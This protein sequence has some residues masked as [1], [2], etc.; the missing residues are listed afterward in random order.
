[1]AADFNG[2]GKLDLAMANQN[3]GTVSILLGNGN[4]TFQPPANVGGFITPTWIAVGDFNGDGKLDLAVTDGGSASVA[5]LLGNGDG[6]FAIG[7]AL[8]TNQFPVYVVTG[9]FNGDGKLDLAATDVPGSVPKRGVRVFLGNGDGTFQNG[10]EYASNAD[11]LQMIAADMNGDGKLDLIAAVSCCDAHSG[12]AALLLGNGDGTF[13]AAKYYSAN[14]TALA[15]AAGDF[16]ADGSMDL[17]VSG[18]AFRGSNLVILL[19]TPAIFSPGSLGFQTLAVGSTSSSQT[20]TLTNVGAGPLLISG[21]A[22]QGTNPGDFAESDDC[23]A[24]L[25]QGAKCTVTVTFSPTSDG[26]RSAAVNFSA[27]GAPKLQSLALKG[28]GTF[29]GLSP[30][31]LAFGSVPVGSTSQPQTVTLTNLSSTKTLQNIQTGVF[32][33]NHSD[34][35]IL[36][37]TCGQSLAPGKNCSVN[38]V[39]TPQ[40]TGSRTAHFRVALS[41]TNPPAGLPLSGTGT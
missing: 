34:F 26:T 19:Q 35:G 6:T 5:I 38:I 13:Q 3:D 21:R 23:P 20:A 10:I 7:T 11:Y 41:G 22:V 36:T 27:T 30:A 37:S 25:A 15:L 33:T 16:F 40:A 24:S 28:I 1:M 12:N 9:D 29:A 17:A 14:A 32:G 39:F 8:S 18:G 2:D 31:S 4:G